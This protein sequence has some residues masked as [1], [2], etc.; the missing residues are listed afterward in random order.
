MLID[1]WAGRAMYANIHARMLCK[2][3]LL[4]C[5]GIKVLKNVFKKIYIKIN[6]FYKGNLGINY[7]I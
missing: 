6:Y 5:K 2:Q 7:I 1:V 4:G 3:Y